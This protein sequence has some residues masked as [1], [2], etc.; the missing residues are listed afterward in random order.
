M[1]L[2]SVAE[3]V[4]QHSPCKTLVVRRHEREFVDDEHSEPALRKI[5]VP[6]DFSDA[7]RS[8]IGEGVAL[9]NQFGATLHL[10]HVVEDNSP[11]VSQI[12]LAYPVFQSYV[13]ELVKTGQ[14]Q[15]DELPL[16]EGQVS[17][18]IQ[19]KVVIGDPINKINNYAE[20][21]G[22]DLIVMGT[23]GRTGPSHWLLG[24]VAERVAR[25]APC[26]VLVTPPHET[27][28][29]SSPAPEAA[30]AALSV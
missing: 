12:S 13:H 20:E 27:A 1:V 15:L 7:G 28:T 10:L 21:Q 25:S 18:S 17:P 19:R 6:V 11:S 4:V 14:K 3:K 5:L 9:A 30:L 24:S 16:P 8:A 22:V 23:H 26:P 29:K 2:G